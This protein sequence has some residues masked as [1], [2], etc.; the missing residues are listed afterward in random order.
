MVLDSVSQLHHVFLGLLH[1]DIE[2]AL[3]DPTS[4]AGSGYK[5]SPLVLQALIIIFSS[6]LT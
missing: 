1:F 3:A 6:Y 2:A 5:C 4:A